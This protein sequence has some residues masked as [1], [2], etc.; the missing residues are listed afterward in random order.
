MSKLTKLNTLADREGG[1]K[2][3][4]TMLIADQLLVIRLGKY[5]YIWSWK[6]GNRSGKSQGILHSTICGNTGNAKWVYWKK[7]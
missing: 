3:L 2:H 5:R 4:S 1:S 6:C 7:F